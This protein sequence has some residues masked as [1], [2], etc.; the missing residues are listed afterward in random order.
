MQND[1]K[2]NEGHLS[3]NAYVYVRQSSA[4][5][6]EHN[7]ESQRLQYE[8][9][10][11]AKALGFKEVIVIDQDLALSAAGY[12]ERGGFK[13]LVA[14]VSANLA[15][16]V[17]GSETARFARNGRDW[18]QL[19]DLCA[20]FDTLLVEQGVVYDPG[21]AND[22]MILSL[23]GTMSE[24]ELNIMKGRMLAGAKNKAKRGELIYRLAV[25]YIK[26]SDDK[27]EK[28]PNK[29]IQMTIAQ[30]FS[31]F[32]E[33]RS[34]RQAF[35]WFIQE[36]IS[37]PCVSYG[38]FG[39]EITWKP[40][41]YGTI[42]GV[43][44][45]PIYAGAYVHGRR[46]TRTRLE[47]NQIRKT[48]GHPLEMKDW[49]VLLKD[50]HAGYISWKQYDENQRILQEN[51]KKYGPMTRGPVLNGTGLL[52]GLLRC[53]RCAR[54]L[55]VSYGGS[56]G[57]VPNYS[58]DASRVR[59]GAKCI[60]FGGFRVDQATGREVLKVVEPLAT[61]AAFAAVEELNRGISDKRKLLELELEE[62][63][64]EERRAYHQYNR[65][66]PDN[67]LVCDELESKWNGCLERVENIKQRLAQ[68]GKTAAPISEQ[69]KQEILELADELPKLWDAPTTTHAVRKRILRTVIKEIIADVDEQRSM[70][71]L[72]LHWVGGVHTKLEVRKNKIGEHHRSTDKTVVEVV[73]Q[74]AEQLPDQR[75]APVLNRL[76]LKTGAGN[77]WTRG[78]VRV[79][80]NYNKIP[81]YRSNAAQEFM[82]L[83][84]AAASLG[85]CPQS[86]RVLVQQQLISARQVVP[87]APWSIHV[88]E[89]DKKQ[90]RD[91][92]DRIKKGDNRRNPGPQNQTQ[93][94]LF[95]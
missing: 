23:K 1:T 27:I 22:K 6:V 47:G 50:N 36:E 45:N 2:I 19:L 76:R 66:D 40:P 9:A 83:E 11:E 29:K 54:K 26:T 44:K 49:E 61:E 51:A 41:V 8:L 91:A 82:T 95:Q 4:H 94:N 58:C 42:M 63:R 17:F 87:Y 77:A 81:A 53:R 30:V 64:Y 52:A 5:Q 43:L 67:R 21:D 56:S 73:A 59:G 74:L 84:Q 46:E 13:K 90:V 20:L 14:A 37:F 71:V 88:L 12:T 33:T 78:R 28:D 25:G 15:G 93:G 69:A 35:L 75:I 68:L 70:V 7:L 57:Q 31:K 86:V 16:I 65:V 3:R 24:M 32:A 79:L 48:K 39:K 89:L 92:V 72:N 60:S 85:I 34:V 10:R 18:H 55:C 38:R 80:R 62:A